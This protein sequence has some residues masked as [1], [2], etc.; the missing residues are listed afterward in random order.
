MKCHNTKNF[1]HCKLAQQ[2][3]YSSYTSYILEVTGLNT[4][5]DADH[6]DNFSFFLSAP[7]K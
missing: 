6:R 4:G 5:T 3:G 7:G 1:N 2:A